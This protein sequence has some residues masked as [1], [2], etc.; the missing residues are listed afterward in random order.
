MTFVCHF[1]IEGVP[2]AKGRPRFTRKG[3]T[4]T[5]TKT[6]DFEDKVKE[7]A[8]RAMGSSEP[9][10]TPLALGVVSHVPIPASW[11]KKRQEAA[12]N[13]ESNPTTRPDV[14]NYAKLVMDAC[15]GILYIDDS[16]VVNLHASKVYSDY[17]RIEVTL[18]EVLK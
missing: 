6:R 17:P 16:Q 15:N 10:E 9:L 12:K 13:G 14:D 2:V 4:Y 3:H 1:T 5:P 7:A 8:R 11:S 18:I